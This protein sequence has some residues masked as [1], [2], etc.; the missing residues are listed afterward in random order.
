M[1]KLRSQIAESHLPVS[2]QSH[3]RGFIINIETGGAGVNA[4]A[5]F[6][7]GV[8]FVCTGPGTVYF[9]PNEARLLLRACAVLYCTPRVCI[10]RFDSVSVTY[11]T[12]ASG[13][14]CNSDPPNILTNR[15]VASITVSLCVLCTL[16][17]KLGLY[18][19]GRQIIDM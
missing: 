18:A 16:S 4:K 19:L 13:W 10:V 9:S 7:L 1:L 2:C 11:C 3:R 6:A 14:G 17:S 12:L 15:W 8:R 5:H